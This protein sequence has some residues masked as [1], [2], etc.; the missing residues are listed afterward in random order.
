MEC[1]IDIDLIQEYLDNTL[2]PLHKVI[3]EEHLKTCEY[4]MLQ[5]EEMQI[6]FGNL[7]IMAEMKID[8]PPEVD[9]LR[10]KTLDKLPL[11]SGSSHFGVKEM[12]YIQKE[13]MEKAGM[14]LQYM[15]G[16]KPGAKLIGKGIKKAPSILYK[17]AGTLLKAGSKAALTR[18]WA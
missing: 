18:T 1:S 11:S 6:L 3:L 8:I 2:D 12:I 15:P 17:A 4:C 7:D 14:F 13:I 5:L 10:N 9:E 16:V